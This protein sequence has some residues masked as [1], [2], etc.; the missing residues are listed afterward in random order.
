MDDL[1]GWLAEWYPSAY[2]SACLVLR[3]PVAAEDA[4]QEAFLR[5]WRFRDAIPAGDGR[6]AWL[7]RHRRAGRPAGSARL[8][9]GSACSRPRRAATSPP[10]PPPRAAPGRPAAYG[11]GVPARSFEDTLTQVRG[12]GTVQSVS[13]AGRDVTAAYFDLAAR[14]RAF[15]ATRSTYLTLLSKARTTG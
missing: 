9:T 1:E 8:S 10:A 15:Q 4:V 2:R 12:Y 3:D 7:Y 6:R 11:C 13:S 14:L 5:V